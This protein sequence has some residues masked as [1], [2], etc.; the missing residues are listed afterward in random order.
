MNFFKKMSG[1][2]VSPPRIHV[3]DMVWS[4]IGAFV[5]IAAIGLLNHGILGQTDSVLM[6]GSFGA[7]SVLV[8]G[9]IRSPLSQPRNVLGGHILSALIGVACYKAFSAH[10]WLAGSLAVSWSIVA[11]HAT[12]TLHPP[13]GAT[14]LIA[15]VGSPKIH[16][17]GLVYAFFPIGAGAM[18]LLVV[19]LIVNN[20]PRSRRYPEFWF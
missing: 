17:L 18:V 15:V 6:I 13:A 11:M 7:S 5:G 2:T 8:Y 10:V 20:I 14:A 12:R 19:A 4:W 1:I 3:A 16:D 9:A